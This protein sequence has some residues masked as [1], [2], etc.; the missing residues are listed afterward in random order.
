MHTSVLVENA[1]RAGNLQKKSPHSVPAST[2]DKSKTDTTK[3]GRK[4]RTIDLTDQGNQDPT[5]K[6][7]L[8]SS[9]IFPRS[10][11]PEWL[12]Q[13]DV[14]N[15]LPRATVAN[16]I[17][18]HKMTQ[19]LEKQNELKVEKANSKSVKKDQ[20]IKTMK[21]SEGEDNV[22]T[23]LHDQRFMF[24]TP[25]LKPETYW[26]KYPI[27]WG[28]TNKKVH[29]SHLGL[30]HV[31][32][33]KTL[34]LVHDRSNPSITIKMF[35]NVNVM[36][37]RDGANKMN[38]VKQHGNYIE[39]ESRDSWLEM[40][41]ISQLEEALDNMVRLWV[42]MW[43]GE[44]GPAN[45]RGVITKHKSFSI[46]FNNMDTRKKV[47]EDFINRILSDNATR[48]GQN[49]PPL[50]YKEIDERAKY[51]IERKSEYARIQ[52][53]PSNRFKQGGN[54]NEQQRKVR[55]DDFASM[56]RYLG[57]S[58]KTQDICAWFNLK[59]GCQKPRCD[60]KHICGNVLSGTDSPCGEKHGKQ[61]CKKK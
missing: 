34:E 46:A 2:T 39:V 43:P 44:F 14:I 17:A 11:R 15:S 25:L 50:S 24:R 61:D 35:S 45:L 18:Q 54:R 53:Q 13:D 52:Q 47:L 48:A 1:R 5:K 60:R 49:L 59:E 58:A 21:V 42:V 9:D 37:G 51:L 30:D 31:V 22:T 6:V 55:P 16:V 36:I 23:K 40:A 57:K 10:D 19:A 4:R 28:E 29:L 3:K 38:R 56:K 27:K 41:N 33:A 20:E 7:K 12:K 26:E 8:L 32:S